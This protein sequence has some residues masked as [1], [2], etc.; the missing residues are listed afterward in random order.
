[1]K[2]DLFHAIGL[3]SSTNWSIGAPKQNFGVFS[4]GVSKNHFAAADT[5]P[6]PPPMP[7]SLV[8]FGAR[9]FAVLETVTFPKLRRGWEDGA[10]PNGCQGRQG[11][12]EAI[13]KIIWVSIDIFDG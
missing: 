6:P 11:L 1:M 10:V 13:K 3:N 8:L 12:R 5:G 9:N 7:Q 2:L 4:P